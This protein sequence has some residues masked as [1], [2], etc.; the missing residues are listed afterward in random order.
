MQAVERRGS[1][2]MKYIEIEHTACARFISKT[3]VLIVTATD[4]ETKGLHCCLIPLSGENGILKVFIG[5]HTYYIGVL[6]SYAV[7]HVQCGMGAVGRGSAITTGLDAIDTWHPKAVIMIG[8]AFGI[9]STTQKIGDV[10]ISESIFPYDNKKVGK[11]QTI[12]RGPRPQAGQVLLNRFKNTRGWKFTTSGGDAACHFCPILSGET[13]VDN[14][15]FRDQLSTQFPTARGGEMEGA[16]I[17]AAAEARKIEWILV[18]GICDF[19]DGEKAVNK[20][21]YQ[22]LAIN[23]ATKY[24]EYF[25]SNDNIL[26]ALGIKSIKIKDVDRTSLVPKIL[27]QI[28]TPGN[29][30]YYYSREIDTDI[31]SIMKN[32]GMWVSGPCGSGKTN[33][34]LRNLYETKKNFIFFDLSVCTG[35]KGLDL[36]RG[37][38]SVIKQTLQKNPAVSP[39]YSTSDII[40]GISNLISTEFDGQDII[41]YFDEIPIANGDCFE[42]F[43]ETFFAIQINLHHRDPDTRVKFIFSTISEPKKLVK[44]HQQKINERIKFV[45]LSA[46]SEFEQAELFDLISSGLSYPFETEQKKLILDGGN[47]TPRYIKNFFKNLFIMPAWPLSR[48]ITET[49]KEVSYV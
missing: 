37:I 19:A 30:A 15:E 29:E 27:F 42:D 48:V 34:I 2:C 6:G 13:L 3:D 4:I 12:Y 17:Y 35:R 39:D 33:L 36:F 43:I 32:N 10:L 28:Y 38:Y 8:I 21:E 40:E 1:M 49:K 47:A 11:E 5:N 22:V 16:G 45:H 18:K 25:L 41:L 9:D 44:P 24:C 31:Q 7:V 46:W 23:S 14:K 26:E 20:H